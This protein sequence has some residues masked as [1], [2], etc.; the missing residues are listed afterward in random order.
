[1]ESLVKKGTFAVLQS[2]MVNE[3][4]LKGGKLIVYAIIYGFSQ[5]GENK[6]TGSLRYLSDWTNSSKKSVMAYLKELCEE[7]LI[8]KEEYFTNGVKYCKYYAN[9]KKV[10]EIEYGMEN[11]SIGME[12]MSIGMEN[13]SIGMEKKYMGGMLKITPNNI[14][15]YN[16]DNNID[17]RIP[18]NG[19]TQ[20][21]DCVITTEEAEHSLINTEECSNRWDTTA[22]TTTVEDTDV[23]LAYSS[24]DEND[25]LVKN[26]TNEQCVA[27]VIRDYSSMSDTKQEEAPKKKKRRSQLE[28]SVDCA[29]EYSLPENV[30]AA[31]TGYFE[32]RQNKIKEK[33]KSYLLSLPACK[34]I[35]EDKVLVWLKESTEE[36]VINSIVVSTEKQYRSL[37]EAKNSYSGK[38]KEPGIVG[39]KYTD[40]DK[41]E[42]ERLADTLEDI[43]EC[44]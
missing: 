25:A 28:R 37:F 40:E 5:D 10:Y 42:K 1:M 4:K 17:K 44:F 35:I 19:G 32:M 22:K 38:F 13:M 43:P 24:Y 36:D 9:L 34:R 16:I 29:K 23:H 3:F 11:M 6:F 2:F 8:I 14:D 27:D 41:I 18:P 30:L 39:K 31:L 20:S 15:I 33:D 21:N 12:N 26:L 7:D